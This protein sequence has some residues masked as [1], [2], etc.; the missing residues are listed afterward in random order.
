[1][2]RRRYYM[3]MTCVV[4]TILVLYPT[5]GQEKQAKAPQ[6]SSKVELKPGANVSPWGTIEI[7]LFENDAPKT[8]ENFVKLAER[9][10]FDGVIFHRVSKEFVIQGGDPTGTGRG[11]KTA[12]GKQLDDELNPAA[13]SYKDGYKRGTVAMANKGPNT[14]TSQFFIVLKDLPALPKAYTIFGKVVKGMEVVDRIGGV[15]ITPGMGQTDGRP[16]KD[17]VM[18]TVTIAKNPGGN[19][20][21]KIEVL[22]REPS[23]PK[24][25]TK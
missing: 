19:P 15:D 5:V 24:E 11:G 14:N 20:H 21:A 1:M 22:Q 13:A 12:S 3:W 25:K 9:K 8:A 18:K 10:Y 7:E 6:K 17:I 2:T 23:A 16:V 4:M